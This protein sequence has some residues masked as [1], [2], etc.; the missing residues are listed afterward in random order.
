[1][2]RLPAARAKLAAYPR[3]AAA[4]AFASHTTTTTTT[5]PQRAQDRVG[6]RSPTQ[7]CARKHGLG[8][9][10]TLRGMGPPD[11]N[12]LG[13]T[14]SALARTAEAVVQ[15]EGYFAR[16]QAVT[17][18][19]VRVSALVRLCGEQLR[20]RGLEAPLL[21]STLALDQ[22]LDGCAALLDAYLMLPPPHAVPPAA[23]QFHVPPSHRP[24]PPRLQREVRLATP[25]DVGALIKWALGRLSKRIAI[26]PDEPPRPSRK[27]QQQQSVV[28]VHEQGFLLMDTYLRWRAD[29]RRT[30]LRLKSSPCVSGT[31]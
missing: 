9:C 25:H 4:G 18:D 5:C 10:G 28:Y 1:M 8:Q 24:L 23:M 30:S 17:L 22:T 26:P 13:E 20:E 31:C 12:A 21:F 11:R 7:H 3:A 14:L 16:G 29:E 19:A 6:H 27:Q 15:P 2:I